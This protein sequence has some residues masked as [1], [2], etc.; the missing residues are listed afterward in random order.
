MQFFNQKI[1]TQGFT[2]K[3]YYRLNTN[4]NN[5]LTISD[6][7]EVYQKQRDGLNAPIIKI[8]TTN[9]IVMYSHYE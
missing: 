6:V 4:G 8:P 1:L 5:I 2:S 7:Y 3:D 9:T